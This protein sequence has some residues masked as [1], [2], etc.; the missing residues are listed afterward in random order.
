MTLTVVALP[1]GQLRSPKA[2]LMS[3]E[4]FCKLLLGNKELRDSYS[5]QF[6]HIISHLLYGP[7]CMKCNL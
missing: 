4:F 3:V 7:S 2:T 6:S 1:E 5:E